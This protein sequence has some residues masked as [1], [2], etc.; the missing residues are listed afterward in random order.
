MSIFVARTTTYRFSWIER[1]SVNVRTSEVIERV[2]EKGVAHS[3]FNG[4]NMKIG[5]CGSL[6]IMLTVLSLPTTSEAFSRRSHGS[7]V[8][9]SQITKP[10][11][12][13]TNENGNGNISGQPVPE[14]PVL[15]LMT[16]G[17]GAFSLLAGIRQI[18]PR[19]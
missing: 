17:L 15:L 8:G 3:D 2:I 11:Q 7:E 4:G 18:R 14:P 9:P 6:I 1:V 5:L 12:T 10:L 16:I 13:P 19:T